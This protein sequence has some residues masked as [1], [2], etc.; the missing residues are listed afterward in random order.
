MCG[1]SPCAP[2]ENKYVNT[3][4]GSVS[5]IGETAGMGSQGRASWRQVQ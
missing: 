2:F 4:S 1:G 3:S 5:V